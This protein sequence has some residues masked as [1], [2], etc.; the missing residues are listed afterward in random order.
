MVDIP[1]FEFMYSNVHRS[2]I[3][4]LQCQFFLRLTE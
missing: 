3:A 2:Y 4:L 1:I